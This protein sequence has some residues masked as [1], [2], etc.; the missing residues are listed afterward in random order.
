[1]LFSTALFGCWAIFVNFIAAKTGL[2]MEEQPQVITL[3]AA[4]IEDLPILEYWDKQQHVIECDPNDDW[5]WATELPKQVP[6]REQLMAELNGQPLGFIQIID[7]ALEETH[8]WGDM[9]DDLRAIDIWIGLKENLGKGYGTRMMHLAIERC[10]ADERVTAIYIDPLIT[11]TAA[12][13]FYERLGFRFVENRIF[14][15]DETA[16]YKLARHNWKPT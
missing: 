2:V 10:F 6:W 13:R 4:T 15:N 16:V 5:E 12:R 9:P 8:Y 14:G 3:R 7:P 11:N 1:L